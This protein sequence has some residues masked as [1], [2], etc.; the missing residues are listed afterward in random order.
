MFIPCP[1]SP[2]SSIFFSTLPL[3]FLTS[4]SYHKSTRLP[5]RH[6]P[7]SP[8]QL[9]PTSRISTINTNPPPMTAQ[10]RPQTQT[11]SPILTTNTN[12]IANPDN[13]HKHSPK[14]TI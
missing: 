11:P 9:P 1:L 7:T 5:S 2:Q 6:R 3:E 10:S 13:K 8:D 12:A 14:P 4:P